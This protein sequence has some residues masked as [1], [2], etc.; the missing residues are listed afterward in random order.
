M[1]LRTIL[2]SLLALVVLLVGG[3]L[4]VL[5]TTDF[6]KYRGAIEAKVSEATGRAF[7]IGSNFR[8]EIGLSPKLVANDVVFANAP[9]GS[10]PDMIVVKQF[11]VQ[12]NL[13]PLLFGNLSVAQLKLVDANILLE[14]DAHG[15]GN[16]EFET[17]GTPAA[18]PQAPAPE[19]RETRNGAIHVPEIHDVYFEGVLLQFHDGQTNELRRFSL[20]HLR[21]SSADRNAP[22]KIDING[23]YNDFYFEIG[24]SVGSANA[25]GRR[26][27]PS[28]VDIAAKLGATDATVR[29]RGEFKEPLEARGYD[30]HVTAA[31]GELAQI[32]DFA[33]DAHFATF[34]LPKLGPLKA[35]FRVRDAGPADAPAGGMPSLASAKID[36][37]REDLLRLQIGGSVRDA[38]ELKG[39][40]LDATA[41]GQEIGALSGLVLP[42]VPSG[43][44]QIPPLG[45]YKLAVKV[46]NGADHISLPAVR[47]DLGRDD[48]LKLTV[49][50]AIRDPLAGKGYALTVDGRT[51]DLA[52][53]A[54]QFKL[55]VPLAGPLT[56]TGKIA[57]AGPNR[58][59]L[60]GFEVKAA[61]SDLG[62]SGSLSLAGARPAATLDLASTTIDLGKITPAEKPAAPST[63]AP[64]AKPSGDGRVF[65]ADPLP[66]DVLN[67]L[68]GDLRYRAAT[69]RTPDGPQFRD[70]TVQATLHD[71]TL[72]VQPISTTIGN[73]RVAGTLS[74]ANK[75]DTLALKLS[76]RGVSLHEIDREVPGP[77]L[78]DGGVTNADIDVRGS[79]NSVRAVMGNLTGT[80]F[81]GIGPGTFTSRYTDILGVGGL[82]NL[83]SKSL[84][85]TERTTLHCLVTRF[86]V[87]DGLARSRVLVAD[88]G[89]MTL[90]GSGTINLKDERLDLG[91]DTHTKVTNL[92]SL[93][94]PVS[95]GGTLADPDFEPDVGAAAAGVIGNVVGDILRQPGNLIDSIFGSSGSPDQKICA[96]AYAKAQVAALPG[97]LPAGGSAATPPSGSQ[98]GQPA[99]QPQK[100]APQKKQTDA[101]QDLGQGVQRGLQGLFGR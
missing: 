82:M 37:G 24:G 93:M 101:I 80:I 86:D 96:A 30:L 6:S 71:G 10:R 72:S 92:L 55:S 32:A 45:P 3:A 90:D 78:V 89:R 1:R 52:A 54:S 77:D 20:G 56:L 36:A 43:L 64:G 94:P 73:G 25:L 87:S 28:P 40:A 47:L 53:A 44:P 83:V 42:G 41:S 91:L 18:A 14:T 12:I 46:T 23:T 60:S 88:T 75:T 65:P 68:D 15:R 95:V 59:A 61:D 5:L 13:L 35:D 99:P 16:W 79:G 85:R 17:T 39:I 7:K 58:Y 27:T 67:A 22:L 63:P 4:A 84:P 29:V 98:P 11:E 21:L 100:A 9:W 69:I 62:G 81:L 74:L 49:S 31:T 34:R 8:V 26:G 33:R 2:L 70:T 97:A 51:P 76:V 50:G 38:V 66:W 57:D 19:E 48:Q